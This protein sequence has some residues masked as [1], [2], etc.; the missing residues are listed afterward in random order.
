MRSLL[1]QSDSHWRSL[2]TPSAGDRGRVREGK[3]RRESQEKTDS[4]KGGR[5]R[6]K[7]K[8]SGVIGGLVRL[9]CL[10]WISMDGSDFPLVGRLVRW[11]SLGRES[12]SALRRLMPH[13]EG[14]D[15]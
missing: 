3:R 7:S 15:G 14:G 1:F 10:A 11:E 6:W 8:S 4:E 5:D 9:S 12:V 2:G 13:F